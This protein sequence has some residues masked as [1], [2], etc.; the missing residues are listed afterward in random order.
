MVQEE[1]IGGSAACPDDY[2]VVRGWS[3]GTALLHEAMQEGD[4]EDQVKAA[5]RARLETRC[6][7]WALRM[8]RSAH[9]LKGAG[10]I[11]WRPF[12]G[13]AMALLDGQ[14]AGDDPD[15]GVCLPEN[16]QGPGKRGTA[17]R[18]LMNGGAPV[19]GR[20]RV[21]AIASAYLPKNGHSVYN[22]FSFFRSAFN[23]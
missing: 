15:H 18:A 8:L 10:N 2:I 20:P 4:D 16:L 11:D 21:R 9:V 6:E 13:T 23:K 12:A 1:L 7:H 19:P 22:D 14:G 3:Q 5:F 17:Q